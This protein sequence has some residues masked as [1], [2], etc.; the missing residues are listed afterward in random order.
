[1][2]SDLFFAIVLLLCALVNFRALLRQLKA[3][4]GERYQFTL[5]FMGFATI[6]CSL[7]SVNRFY[8]YLT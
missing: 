5:W 3:P 6:F 4:P 8:Q 1:M 7:M 2:N